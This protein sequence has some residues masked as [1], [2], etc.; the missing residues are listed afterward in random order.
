M[1]SEETRKDKRFPLRCLSGLVQEMLSRECLIPQIGIM[2]G[3]EA[4]F[5]ILAKSSSH[6]NDT[7]VTYGEGGSFFFVKAT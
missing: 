4:Y 7:G 1:N 5:G 6:V 3:F 2:L